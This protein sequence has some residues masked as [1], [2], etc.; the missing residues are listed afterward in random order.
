[1]KKLILLSVIIASIA[2]PARAARMTD[3]RKGFKKV[4][5]HTVAFNVIYLVLLTLV[6]MRLI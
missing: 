1:M 3:A 6:F 5:L 2:I 4:M